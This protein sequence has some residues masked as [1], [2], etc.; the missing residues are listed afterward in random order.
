MYRNI[1][2]RSDRPSGYN[3]EPI[4]FTALSIKDVSSP[5]NCMYIK[6]PAIIYFYFRS[7]VNICKYGLVTLSIID[8]RPYVTLKYVPI[9]EVS[10]TFIKTFVIPLFL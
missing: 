8:I 1:G 3:P 2:I 4:T 10:E 7:S 6:A 9:T 5:E